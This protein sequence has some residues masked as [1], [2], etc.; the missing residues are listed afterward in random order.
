MPAGPSCSTRGHFGP[1]RPSSRRCQSRRDTHFGTRPTM[2]APISVGSKLC[3]RRVSVFPV[4]VGGPGRGYGRM[5][6]ADQGLRI[7]IRVRSWY[8]RPCPPVPRC[9]YA[10]G[11]SVVLTHPVATCRASAGGMGGTPCPTVGMTS[12]LAGQGKGP[13]AFRP[14]S[15][16]KDAQIRSITSDNYG[17][18][19]VNRRLGLWHNP[20]FRM[21][22]FRLTLCADNERMHIPT[23]GYDGKARTRRRG[24]FPAIPSQPTGRGT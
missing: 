5:Y 8:V 11:L 3:E 23:D 7:P 13:R 1:L 20:H 19:K 17:T 15:Q 21:G 12:D 9:M 14:C 22:F 24:G 6:S 4:R 2:R 10:L 18:R 16:G